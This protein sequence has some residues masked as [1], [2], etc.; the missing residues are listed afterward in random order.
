[1]KIAI[2]E[3]ISKLISWLTKFRR[4]H[5]IDSQ[6]FF[7]DLYLFQDGRYEIG[8]TYDRNGN[9]LVDINLIFIHLEIEWE[10]PIVERVNKLVNRYHGLN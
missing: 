10:K 4:F 3:K 1:M 7:V 9:H 2:K 6:K 8:I 5:L